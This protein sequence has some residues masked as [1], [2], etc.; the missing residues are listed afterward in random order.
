MDLKL[1][2]AAKEI[3]NDVD[4]LKYFNTNNGEELARDYLDEKLPK[5]AQHAVQ[6]FLSKYG[7]RG[8]Y[9]IDFGRP[10]WRE[11]P[12]PLMN[13]LKSYVEIDA[14]HAPD[15]VFAAGEVAAKD[16]IQQLG[17]KLG[18]PWLVSFLARRIRLL[19]GVRELPKFTAIRIMGHIRE[20]ILK[21][22]ESLVEAGAID[23]ATDLFYL[24]MDEV[25]SLA[26]RKLVNCKE[27]IQERKCTM[28]KETE[29]THLPRVIASDGFAYF[30]GSVTTTNREQSSDADMLCGEPVS[31]GVYEGRI[32]IVLDPSKT[33][34]AQGEI[35]CCHGTDPSWTPLFLSAGALVMEVGGLMTREFFFVLES[36]YERFCVLKFS[37]LF[38]F[39]ILL[40]RIYGCERVWHSCSCWSRKSNRETVQWSACAG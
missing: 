25:E 4:S 33:K 9:E 17:T 5:A 28:E 23:N 1:W 18:K 37:K 8:L 35:L 3:Q 19:A 6:Q 22:G 20:R 16:A 32:R 2:Q 21:E 34:L 27:L 38:T 14:E 24:D 40:R 10:R 12:T 26:K 15:K 30:G 7:C 39:M 11:D 36:K 31:P 29:R 13:T